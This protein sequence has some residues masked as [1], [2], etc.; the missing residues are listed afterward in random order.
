MS[1]KVT[2]T[3]LQNTATATVGMGAIHFHGDKYRWTLSASK[4][5][6]EPSGDLSLEITNPVGLTED[7]VIVVSSMAA[8]VV[9]SMVRKGGPNHAGKAMD[10]GRKDWNGDNGFDYLPSRDEV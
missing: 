8:E 9:K 1:L 6:F 7:Q 10:Y 4:E 5:D 2:I 3:D